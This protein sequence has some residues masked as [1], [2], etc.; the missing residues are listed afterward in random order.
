MRT[1]RA[2]SPSAFMLYEKDKEEYCLR[3]LV[4]NRPPRTKQP[5]PASVGS[6]FDSFVKSNIYAKL[7]GPNHNPAYSFDALFK[8]SVE[9]HNRDEAQVMGK[10]C[11]DNYIATGS[12]D[13]LLESMQGAQEDPSFE[14]TENRIIDN[15]PIT[16]KPDA[17]FVNKDGVHV[18]L[19]WKVKGY[20]SKYGASPSQGYALCR[21]GLDWEERNLTKKQVEKKLAGEEVTGKHSKSHDTEH[22]KYLS[23]NFKGLTINQGY[24]ET[25]NEGWAIQLAMYSWMKGEEVGDENVVTCIDELVC[26]FMGAGQRPLIRVAN[27]KARIQSEFQHELFQRLKTLWASINSGWIFQDESRENSN[28]QFEMISRRACGMASDGSAEEDWINEIS[29]P[30]YR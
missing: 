22:K 24:L 1:P 7:F 5:L 3:H 6:A 27:H 13:E 30:S 9:A 2:L 12:Y 16:G 10:H 17:R 11:L 28:Q 15:V 4:D 25:C 20:C 18:I 21:D 26:K 23:M 29:R 8:D 14:T 19:D